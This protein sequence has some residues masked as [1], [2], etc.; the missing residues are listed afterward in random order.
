MGKSKNT[1]W[2]PFKR[3]FWTK[4]NLF[5]GKELNNWKDIHQQWQHERQKQESEKN[6]LEV[7]GRK[8]QRA[9]CALTFLLTFPIVGF[10]LFGLMGLVTGL[11]VGGILFIAMLSGN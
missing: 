7:A 8:I 6:R 5:A 4:E 2:N 9:G 1:V 3:A 11:M 10:A